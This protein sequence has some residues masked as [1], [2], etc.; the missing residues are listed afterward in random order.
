MQCSEKHQNTG[1]WQRPGMLLAI[2]LPIIVILLAVLRF[3]GGNAGLDSTYRYR[4]EQSL[5]GNVTHTLNQEI[6]F[7]QERISH[8]PEGGLD[9]ASLA[10]AY[11]KMARATGDANWYLLAEQTAKRSLVQLPFSN[12]GATLA[13]A[14]VAEA[15]H[16][17]TE[18]IDLAT[19]VLQ[20]KLGN[21]DALSILVTSN[22]AMGKVDEASK[23]ADTLVNQI[24]SIG[25]LALHALVNQA[26]G[27]DEAVLQDFKQALAAEEP[28]EAGS[29]AWVRTMLG[30]FY[31]K[32]GNHQLAGQLY[33]EALRIL[34]RYPLA[35]VNLA[36]LE[37]RLGRYQ[38][39]E[40]YY[41]QVF[42]SP[43][44]P[45][46]FDH[47]ALHGLARVKALQGHKSKAKE[48]WHQAEALLR[49][50][51]DV[52]S[53]G[54]RR[55]LARLLL[56]SDRPQDKAEALTLMQ[57]EVQLRRD[58]ETLDTLAWALSSAG[59]W[60]EAQGAIRE[61]LRWGIRDAAMFYR[62]GTIEEKLGNRDRA[63]AYFQLAQETDPTFDER[64]WRTVELGELTE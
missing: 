61:A 64:A 32:R 15:R 16:D 35:L 46:I 60:E 57:E 50:H 18:A 62:A 8:N 45:N 12:S 42:V 48:Q 27:K 37:T 17:F 19:Q 11:L 5:S 20:E 55:E 4:F 38:A 59:R 41:T 29:S 25:S 31:F 9:R 3:W 23:A 39:A 34:P 13:L 58:P 53:F 26:Q 10:K 24:P 21:E 6:K 54:H 44:Y 43:A 52:D 56:E 49:D 1:L 30:R 2:A 14:R 28:G 47:V 33:Q 51:L 36:E 40:Q 63:K 22:L 7:Y